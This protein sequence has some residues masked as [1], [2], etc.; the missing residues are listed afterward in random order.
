MAKS[1]EVRFGIIGTGGR[2]RGLISNYMHVRGFKIAAL[3]DRYEHQVKQA[4]DLVGDPDVVCYLDHRKM[5]KDANIDAVCVFTAPELNVPLCCEALATGKHVMCEV[6]LCLTLEHCW[7]IVTAVE[8]SG[9]KFQMAEQTRYWPF[10]QAWKKLFREGRLGKMLFVRGEYIHPYP[11][12]WEDAKTGDKLSLEDAKNHP[13]KRKARMFNLVH[14]IWYLPHELSPV[15]SILDDRVKTVT[16]MGTRK[17]SY[18][19]DWL[20][21]PDIETAT[22]HT[23]KDTVLSLTAGFISPNFPKPDT[24]YHWYQLMGTGGSVETARAYG[25]RMKMWLT[26]SFM[27]HPATVSWEFNPHETPAEAMASGHG[28]IDYYPPATF[29]ESI[30][31]DKTPPMDIYTAVE[32][33][34]PAILAGLSVDQGSKCLEVPEFRPVKNRKAGQMPPTINP[35]HKLK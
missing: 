30:L 4:H 9:L 26:D 20:E 28:G 27:N 24:G 21:I 7:Q 25:D 32:T 15:L 1:K 13:N 10:I 19:Y 3:C 31:K 23:E 35:P 33:A 11:M 6:P 14:P 22:M 17:R 16:C 29:V 5:L 8:K 34:A 18:V 2:G 12:F